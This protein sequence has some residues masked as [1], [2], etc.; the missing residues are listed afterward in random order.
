DLVNARYFS[1]PKAASE[2]D[3]RKLRRQHY[4]LA[5][6]HRITLFWGLEQEPDDELRALLSG[7]AF[8]A[9]AGYHGPGAG[10]GQDLLVLE[11]YGGELSADEARMWLAVAVTYRTLRSVFVYVMDEPRASDRKEINRRVRAS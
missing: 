8:S 2:E 3:K 4:Q 1:D 11:A 7:A 9:D 6:Q 5:R 10:L